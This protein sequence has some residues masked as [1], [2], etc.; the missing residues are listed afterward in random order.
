MLNNQV[1][2]PS[3]QQQQMVIFGFEKLQQPTQ[4]LRALDRLL[5]R[6][7]VDMLM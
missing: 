5:L 3:N 7:D 4:F 1:E 6:F 2:N